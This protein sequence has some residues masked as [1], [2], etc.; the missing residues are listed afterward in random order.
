MIVNQS[1]L[2]ICFIHGAGPQGKGKGSDGLASSLQRHLAGCEVKRP[3]MPQPE[4][5]E[6]EAWKSALNKEFAALEGEVLLVGHS[7]GGSVL[8]KYISEEERLPFTIAGLFMLAAP[9]WGADQDWQEESFQ[10]AL[11]PR[12][13]PVPEDKL[14]FYHS[15]E[16]HVVPFSHLDAYRQ[17]YPRANYREL[18]GYS[19]DYR[20]GLPELVEDCLQAW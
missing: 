19:H 10:L 3:S 20:E 14:Y 11:R 17:K 2:A 5:P 7:L 18:N 8:L 9:C 6:Y 4:A 1:H 15:Q 16:D 13:L 12:K